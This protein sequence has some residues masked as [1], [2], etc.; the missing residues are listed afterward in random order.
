MK[1]PTYRTLARV[2]TAGSFDSKQDLMARRVGHL[3][4]LG[5][6]ARSVFCLKGVAMQTC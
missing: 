4:G 1:A 6:P 2:N 3:Q 5:Q